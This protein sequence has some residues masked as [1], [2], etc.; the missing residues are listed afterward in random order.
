MLDRASYIGK[1]H[2]GDKQRG[3][4]IFNTIITKNL[5]YF[6]NVQVEILMFVVH[7]SHMKFIVDYLLLALTVVYS[8]S[9]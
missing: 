8:H 1:P 2:I 7:L 5:R 6:S 9:R 3:R 4:N